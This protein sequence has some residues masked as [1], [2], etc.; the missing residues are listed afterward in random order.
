MSAFSILWEKTLNHLEEDLPMFQYNVWIKDLK[1]F[2][3]ENNTYFFEVSSQ[4]HKNLMAE[5]YED[6]IQA[7]MQAAFEEL[8]GPID[9]S[10]HLEFITPEEIGD[11]FSTVQ[12]QSTNT[13]VEDAATLPPIRATLNPNHTFDTFVVGESNKFA[14]AAAHAV[15]SSPGHAYNPLFLYGGVGL[16]KTHLMHAIGNKILDN[17]PNTKIVYVTSETFTNELINMI[18]RTNN[19][20]NIDMR[21]QFRDKYRKVDV[22]MID[23]IQFIAGKDKTQD[24]FFHTFNALHE[25]NKQIVISS[26]RPPKEMEQLEERMRSRFEWG[27][28]ADIKMPDYE[29]RVAILMKK[30]QLLH[31]KDMLPIKDDVYHF[32]AQFQDANIRTLEGALQKVMMYAELH[33]EQQN[34]K[35]ID[36]PIA[37]KA[38]ADYFSPPSHKTIT[39]KVVVDTVCRFYDIRE[40]DIRGTKKSRDIAFPRQ[41]AMFILRDITELSYIKIAEYF[42]KKDHTTIMYAEDKIRK[43]LK[44]DPSLKRDIEDIVAKIKS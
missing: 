1:P 5:K 13:I 11:K 30:S 33:K 44:E 21:E 3:E 4:M 10:F 38:L 43:Q 9:T 40:E 8:Y 36:L 15:A 27:L 23:D 37:E 17:Q 34:L 6:T 2:I 29:T 16:G 22:L 25:L 14:N 31:S 18:S 19:N 12:P 28:I 41:I 24:E 7:S 42:G 26:D 32:I 39:P 35:E 20:A